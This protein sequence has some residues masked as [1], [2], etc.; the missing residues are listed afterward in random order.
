MPAET[1]QQG[2]LAGREE[3][4]GLLSVLLGDIPEGAT[5]VTLGIDD[6]P[7]LWDLWD[8][9]REEFGERTLGPVDGADVLE[10]TMTVETAA[11]MMARLLT[12][13]GDQD[14]VP[15]RREATGG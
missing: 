10:K 2:R 9:V 7:A 8:A 13:G 6:D 11:T 5:L 4:L 15:S 3:V 12:P 14:P 1:H